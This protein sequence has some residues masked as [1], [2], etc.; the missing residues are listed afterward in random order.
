MSGIPRHRAEQVSKSS[1]QTGFTIDQDIDIL[2]GITAD[3]DTKDAATF[4]ATISG[5]DALSICV[6]HDV[7]SIGDILPELLKY[8]HKNDYKTKGFDWLIT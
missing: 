6:K 4:G 1:D 3:L 2:T 8:A 7:N 5:A